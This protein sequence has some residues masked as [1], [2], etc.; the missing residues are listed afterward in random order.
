M[1]HC[2]VC[3]E[4]VEDN[5][6]LC[7]NCEADR[8]ENIHARAAE[9]IDTG[10]AHFED[11]HGP[12][13]QSAI[14]RLSAQEKFAFARK[15]LRNWLCRR[16]PITI[17]ALLLSAFV[18]LHWCLT[19]AATSYRGNTLGRS[20]FGMAL[21]VPGAVKRWQSRQMAAMAAL[22]AVAPFIVTWATSWIALSYTPLIFDWTWPC[23]LFVLVG[24][25]E[26]LCR[27]DDSWQ[28]LAW[29]MAAATGAAALYAI[30]DFFILRC[31]WNATVGSALYQGS[32]VLMGVF[33][34]LAVAIATRANSNLIVRV[35]Y[36]ATIVGAV[37]CYIVIFQWGI[38][39]LAKASLAGSGPFDNRF[40]VQVL[41]I[42]NERLHHEAIVSALNQADWQ[43][44]FNRVDQWKTP[45]WRHTAVKLLILHNENWAAEQLAALLRRQPTRNLIDMSDRLFV[46]QLRYETAPIYLRYALLDSMNP[47]GFSFVHQVRYLEALQEMKLPQGAYA[48]LQANFYNQIL[49]RAIE[50]REQGKPLELRDE[51]IEVSDELRKQLTAL[52]GIDAGNRWMDWDRLYALHSHKAPTPLTGSLRQEIERTESCLRRYESLRNALLG[53]QQAAEEQG[54]PPLPTLS[55]PNWNV[56]TIEELEAEVRSFGDRVR[57]AIGDENMP[58]QNPD[59]DEKASNGPAAAEWRQKNLLACNHPSGGFAFS[60]WHGSRQGTSS[61]QQGMANRHA[62]CFAFFSLGRRPLIR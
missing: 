2:P 36:A 25:G 40:A 35:A 8:P 39:A 9:A 53:I 52:L 32:V 18:I 56:P 45:D 48:S 42:G 7:W 55:Q 3:G 47:S 34:W 12:S 17:A 61:Q 19:D 23:G 62:D 57:E 11:C 13:G 30:V 29:N 27:D 50:A 38:F 15:W 20:A 41:H 16:S 44:P 49:S 22:G 58:E 51:D 10:S 6:D 5:F 1:W 37:A 31:A 59:F 21:F 46:R 54:R 26:W 33:A 24:I 4:K 43:M 28:Q 60:R 14:H